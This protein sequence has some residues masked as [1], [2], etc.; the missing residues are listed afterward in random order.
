LPNYFEWNK[1][2]FVHAGINLDLNDWKDS[3]DKFFRETDKE[4]YK[5][6]TIQV[7]TIQVKT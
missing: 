7:K 6:K 2:I 4:F 5:E 3:G 1:W